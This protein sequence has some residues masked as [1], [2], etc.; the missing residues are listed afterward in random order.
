[1]VRRAPETL[2]QLDVSRSNEAP[3]GSAGGRKPLKTLTIPDFARPIHQ[4]DAASQAESSAK[5]RSIA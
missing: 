1:M 3:R 2:E 5:E 4:A